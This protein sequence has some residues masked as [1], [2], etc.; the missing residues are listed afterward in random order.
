MALDLDRGLSLQPHTDFRFARATNSVALG[1]VELASAMHHYPIVFTTT[2]RPAALAVLGLEPDLNFFVD[3]DGRWQPDAYIPAY[4]RRY[5]FILSERSDS[6]ELTLCIDEECDRL[7]QSG[8][9]PLFTDGQPTQLTRDAL[10]FCREFHEQTQITATFVAALLESGLLVENEARLNLE[11]GRDITLGEARFIDE[12]KFNA[13]PDTV[14]L[15]WR[16]RG[17]LPLVYSHLFSMTKWRALARL[18]A[19]S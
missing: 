17:W 14:L 15:E 7:R 8:D 10:N 6:T 16:L 4:I 11:P 1:A 5:P 9:Y 12:A 13:L 19:I 18:A 3:D 2:G